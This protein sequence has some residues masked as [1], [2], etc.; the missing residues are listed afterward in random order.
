M[1]HSGVTKFTSYVETI[2]HNKFVLP[3][4]KDDLDYISYEEGIKWLEKEE[5]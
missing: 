3:N 2:I 4:R 5:N 1:N